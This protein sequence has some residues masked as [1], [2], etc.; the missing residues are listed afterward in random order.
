MLGD[1]RRCPLGCALAAAAAW[2][3][4]A[5]D[6]RAGERLRL[7]PS[8]T[9][10]ELYDDNLFSSPE[11]RSQ[12]WITRLSPRLRVSL[13]SPQTAM[14]A[15]FGFD[16]ERFTATPELTDPLAGQEAGLDVLLGV[17]GPVALALGATHAR[18]Q[19]PGALNAFTGLEPGRIPTERLAATGSLW[20][21]LGGRTETSG[22]YAFT[23]DA[24]EGGR[25]ADTEEASL[26]IERQTSPRQGF[27]LGY[28]W[29]RYASRPDA[30]VI[31]YIATLGWERS[32]T[33][34]TAFR[35]AAGP[36]LVLGRAEPQIEASLRWRRRRGE[37]ALA[38]AS[39]I[40][41]VVGFPGVA[42]ADSLGLSLSR[43]LGRSVHLGVN[44]A[45]ARTRI[46][47]RQAMVYRCATELHARLAR[48][49]T[50][51]LSHHFS[52]QEGSLIS[53]ERI[54]H[55]VAMLRIVAGPADGGPHRPE[56]PSR[57]GRAGVAE[58]G[59]QEG[60]R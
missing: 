35:L 6:A 36:R 24:F 11:T 18:T 49:L 52:L 47:E 4:P 10:A 17:R 37:I 57:P 48:R 13:T 23:R 59:A 2:A 51:S 56:R 9:V 16:A 29:R 46:G 39:D 22:A 60:V 14:L 28:A 1:P 45:V 38:L 21:R 3:S 30:P 19:T 31:A 34:R 20:W 41:R 32:L 50:L 44:P 8:L 7:L 42:K 26:A 55:N 40:M 12:D 5:S 53:G 25:D 58:P 27:R 15:R 54:P 43:D 33:P